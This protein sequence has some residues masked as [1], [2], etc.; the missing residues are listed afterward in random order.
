MESTSNTAMVSPPLRGRRL[1]IARLGVAVI[2]TIAVVAAQFLSQRAHLRAAFIVEQVDLHQD[3]AA[4]GTQDR[5][6]QDL[7]GLRSS[8][9]NSNAPKTAAKRREIERRE[10]PDAT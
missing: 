10:E 5:P 7:H 3:T 4:P 9:R 6:A 8:A 2:R 1:H